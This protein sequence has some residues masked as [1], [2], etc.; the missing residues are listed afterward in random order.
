[1]LVEALDLL[2]AELRHLQRHGPSFVISHRFAQDNF[3]VP[4]EEISAVELA[5]DGNTFQLHL[6]LAQRFVFDYLAHHR[7]IA[8]DSLQ[9]VSGLTGDWFYRDHAANSEHPQPK[10]I[11]RP[12]V[13][14]IVQRIRDAMEV[15]FAKAQV[16][17][18][19]HDV[20]RS[21]PA[22]GSKRVL[23]KLCADVRWHH[24]SR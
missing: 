15:A 11:L 7:R 4:G 13:R 9:I 23:Y 20:L 10:K 24:T 1:M 22:E 18:D 8:L 12:T 19:P 6:A 3:C 16:K 21:C 14:V 5:C 2:V 17:L